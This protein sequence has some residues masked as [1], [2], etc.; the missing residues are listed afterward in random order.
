MFELAEYG[1]FGLFLAAFLA[2]TILPFS[3]EVVLTAILY[4]GAD[5]FTCLL[6]ATSG[7]WLGGLTGYLLGR[8]G[9]FEWLEK[10]FKIKKE[11]IE[12][13][14]QR[15]NRTGEWLAF[16]AF[17]PL[18]GDLLSVVVGFLRCR[19]IPVAVLMLLGKFLRYAAWIWL[20][21]GAFQ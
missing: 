1:Y 15:F 6:V 8:L 17:L 20:S 5:E 14:A 18:V 2:A 16:F 12:H 3:S 7:N 10:Y 21:Y 9:K 4:A 13:F 19:M 11:K